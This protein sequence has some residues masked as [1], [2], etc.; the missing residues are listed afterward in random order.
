[1]D[2]SHPAHDK[3]RDEPWRDALL[4]HY[5]ECDRLTG[6]LIAAAGPDVTTLVMSDHGMGPLY[7]DVYL[8]EWLRQQGYLAVRERQPIRQA[9]LARMGVTRTRV[10]AT[11]RGMRLGWLERA[12]KD[13]LGARIR[14][15]PRDRVREL[16]EAVDWGHTRAYSFGYHGQIYLNLKG[17]EPEGI[18][19]PGAEADALRREI[20]QKLGELTDPADGQAVVSA[21]YRAEDLYSGPNVAYA[22]DIIVLMRDL[23]YITR[24]GYEIGDQPGV[25]FGPPAM[26]ESASHRLN[27]LLVAAGPGIVQHGGSKDDI[28]I[29]DVMP[30]ILH[31]MGCEV[32]HGLDGKVQSDWLDDDARRR[33]VKFT[34][35]AGT[36]S[37]AATDFTEEEEAE[38]VERLKDLGYLG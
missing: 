17:R 32:P 20:M 6:E 18:V 35:G 29:M 12:I 34:E 21:M 31:I 36:A 28:S 2:T 37:A 8:N 22:P 5:Q 19:Q 4:E 13:R 33:P 14:V 26:G 23:A 27:G 30:T 15:L 9:A 1:M 3:E 25:L 11:L 7:K 16:E 38:V 10:S 24:R